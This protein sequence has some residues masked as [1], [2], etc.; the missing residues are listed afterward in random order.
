M[1]E[2]EA[3]VKRKSYCMLVTFRVGC[4]LTE[5][6]NKLTVPVTDNEVTIKRPVG[7]YVR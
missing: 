1:N 4:K 5:I 6:L 3:T 7:V 2:D